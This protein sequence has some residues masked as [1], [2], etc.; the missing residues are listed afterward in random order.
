V[1]EES[2]S[3]VVAVHRGRSKVES[4]STLQ[5][6]IKRYAFALGLD[7]N[8]RNGRVV[9]NLQNPSPQCFVQIANVV[10]HEGKLYF[11]SIGENAI[12]RMPLPSK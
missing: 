7:A 10:E 1:K 8:G 3:R 5:P 11:G 12:G 4:C 9:Q 6:N 2:K